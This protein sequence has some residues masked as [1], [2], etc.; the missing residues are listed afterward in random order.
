[1]DGALRAT[2][3]PPYRDH[4]QDGYSPALLQPARHEAKASRNPIQTAAT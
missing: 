3:S 2:K 1:M 4:P